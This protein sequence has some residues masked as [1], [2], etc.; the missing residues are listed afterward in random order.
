MNK[1]AVPLLNLMNLQNT[2]VQTAPF[3]YA[4]IPN[5]INTDYLTQLVRSFP[6]ITH[7]GSVP[8]STITCDPLF[9]QLID[10][11]EGSALR[12]L[13]AEKFSIELENKPTIITLRGHTTPRDG[14]IHTDSK[15]KLIT[16]LIYMNE[17]WNSR[18]GQ[19]RILNG[20]H[21][22]DDYVAEVPALAGTCLIFKV[23]PNCWHGHTTFTG[24]RLS[25]QLNYLIDEAA[26]AK[27]HQHHYFSAKLK[28]WF[29]WAFARGY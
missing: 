9:Q 24:K 25:L 29:P 6:S 23:T 3:P 7:R 12:A 4:V 5:F 15:D 17:N 27:H 10:E 21:S 16:V 20:E 11:L 13:I 26:L 18:E 1:S 19:L 2:P 22:L 28:R 8:V 14:H